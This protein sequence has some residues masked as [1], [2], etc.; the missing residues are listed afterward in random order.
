VVSNGKT[1]IGRTVANRIQSR[2]LTRGMEKGMGGGAKISKRS[3]QVEYLDAMDLPRGFFVYG[4]KGLVWGRW[5]KMG[6]ELDCKSQSSCLYKGLGGGFEVERG[7]GIHGPVTLPSGG[8][9][10]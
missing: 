9:Q 6:G 4:A 5:M 1:I 7:G 3:V 8:G 2:K 10:K